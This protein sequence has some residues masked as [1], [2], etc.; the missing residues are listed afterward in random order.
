MFQDPVVATMII[1]ALI[2]LGEVV[3][4]ATRA[5]VPML[6]IALIGYLLLI[7]AGVMPENLIAD[8]TFVTVGAVLGTAPIV[9]H[10]GTLIPLKLIKSQ[11]KAIAIALT[12]IIFGAGLVLLIVT[13]VFD[14]KTAVAGAGPLT[15]GLIAF[16]VTS[17]ELKKLGLTSLITIP[18]LVL[19]LQSLFG[20]PLAANLLRR[21]ALKLRQSMD[22]GEFVAA[23]LEDAAH[24]HSDK[25]KAETRSWIP[26]KYQSNLILLFLL[27]I[28]GAI[29][30]VL[31]KLTG[32]PYSLWALVIG[33]LGRFVGFYQDRVM[34][35]ANAFTVGMAGL[36]FLVIA[37]MN[38]ITFKMFIG[39]LPEVF[40][41]III[42]IIGIVFGGFLGSKLFKWDPLK[43]IPVAL[44]ATFGFPGD[45]LISEEVSRSVGRNKEEEETIFN[46]ILSPMLIGGFTT[47]TTGSVVI[48]TILLQT[49]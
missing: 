35:R 27:F 11:W 23:S 42:G 21:H 40:L 4:I 48:A 6:L 17:E 45:Y 22:S 7:W 29:A 14:Y 25:A 9:V 36:I 34:E 18:V 19:A 8:S 47:V 24:G 33:I 43:G 3:S 44:T 32:V 12:G 26:K 39:Y 49:L 28:G 15:G 38:E 37:F 41:I 5:R 31:G 16:L 2:A 13:T 30:V 10:M 20:M 1:M 46:E